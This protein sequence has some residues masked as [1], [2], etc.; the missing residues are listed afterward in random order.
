MKNIA[1]KISVDL[2]LI[3]LLVAIFVMYMA[4][5]GVD[6]DNIGTGS[7]F[8]IFTAL[9][10]C[11]LAIQPVV[12]VSNLKLLL[13]ISI[14]SAAIAI[15][16]SVSFGL[17][18]I[19]Y[20]DSVFHALYISFFASLLLSFYFKQS[21]KCDFYSFGETGSFLS[22]YRIIDEGNSYVECE[23]KTAHLYL[24][25]FFV[26]MI[27]FGA[28]L[29]VTVL[30]FA[31]FLLL[32]IYYLAGSRKYVGINREIKQ[33]AA[34]DGVEIIGNKWSFSNPLRVKLPKPA[35]E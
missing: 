3:L 1:I 25:L 16:F 20:R 10:S 21:D 15:G 31:G 27:V 17:E 33:A 13:R 24:T 23:F 32:T 7:W 2:F 28:L 26:L 8:V 6:P 14:F 30:G 18:T 9:I 29:G 22:P 12:W 11:M 35:G 4:Y 19:G 5:S 34:L